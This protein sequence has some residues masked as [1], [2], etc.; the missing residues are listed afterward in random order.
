[1][2]TPEIFEEYPLISHGRAHRHW[3]FL[4]YN[5][6]EDGG[7]ASPLI[8]EAFETAKEP[9]V[10]LNP[11]MASELG[12]KAGDMVWV[13]SQWGKVQGR[14]RLSERIHPQMAVTPYG[15]GGH[16]NKINP[17]RLSLYSGLKLPMVNV[18]GEGK[19]SGDLGGQAT[20]AGIPVKVYKA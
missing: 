18:Y 2:S 7:M 3:T 11:K 14:L 10:E 1:M 4:G 19:M 5:L 20:F 16:Q 12:L 13:E 15:W 9:T 17:V 8:R 6:I